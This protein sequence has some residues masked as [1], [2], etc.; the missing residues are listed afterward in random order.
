M[1]FGDGILF[2]SFKI[3]NKSY[4]F[5]PLRKVFGGPISGKLGNIG[6]IF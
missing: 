3:V 4:E 2:G 6:K 5:G 1:D